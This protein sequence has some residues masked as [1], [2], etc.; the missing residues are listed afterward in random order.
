[1]GDNPLRGMECYEDDIH[2]VANAK[3]IYNDLLAYFASR[4][5]K[6]FVLAISPPQAPGSTDA[7]HAANARALADW[8]R[9]DWLAGYEGRNVFAYDFYNVLTSNSG[10]EWTADIGTAEGNH[11]RV[12][13]GAVQHLQTVAQN[14]SA[15]ARILTTV[16][17]PKPGTRKPPTNSCPS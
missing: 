6:M 2:T 1:M 17:P 13:E 5:D 12:H 11:H 14:T 4:P 9:T 10:D 16:T 3:G 15:Y 7:G 8:L